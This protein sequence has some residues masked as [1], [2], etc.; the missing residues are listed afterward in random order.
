MRMTVWSTRD[1]SETLS[2]DIGLACHPGAAVQR[3]GRPM[4]LAADR[5][6]DRGLRFEDISTGIHASGFGEIGDGRSFAFHLERQ[7]LVVEVYRP[8]L[9]GPVPQAEDVVASATRRL[10]DIDLADERSLAAAVRD[11]IASAQPLPRASR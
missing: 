3:Y 4:T 8:R 2:G 1:Y 5:G 11:A 6:A 10:V 9:A 7:L